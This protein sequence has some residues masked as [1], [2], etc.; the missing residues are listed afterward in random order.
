M[1]RFIWRLIAAAFGF[2]VASQLIPGVHMRGFGSLIAAALLLGVLN[3]LVRPI[4]ILL[5][6]P[7][8]VLTLGLF[9]FVINGVTVW[10]VG[11]IVPGAQIDGLWNAI[12]AALLISLISWLAG[13][14]MGDNEP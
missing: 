10:L 1:D 12:F 11:A 9:L 4:L 6:L 5:T 3:A 14:L 8:S 13:M 7:L 2:W